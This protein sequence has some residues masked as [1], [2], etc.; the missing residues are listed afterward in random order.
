MAVDLDP[1]RPLCS[2]ENSPLRDSR[3]LTWERMVGPGLRRVT[4]ARVG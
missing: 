4:D 1:S 3:A 2:L